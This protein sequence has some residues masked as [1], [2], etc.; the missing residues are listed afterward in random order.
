MLTLR[1]LRHC[2]TMPLITLSCRLTLTVSLPSPAT[3]L[4]S[5]RSAYSRPPMLRLTHSHSRSPVA[6][7]PT[8]HLSGLSPS[9]C[10]L[11]A[12]TLP[13]SLLCCFPQSPSLLFLSLLD[14]FKQVHRHNPLD[15]FSLNGFTGC[16]GDP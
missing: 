6:T 8:S 10:S 3:P 9:L 2:L 12:T 15:P 13:F 16:I 5:R 11:L 7:Q 1:W 4:A 14:P